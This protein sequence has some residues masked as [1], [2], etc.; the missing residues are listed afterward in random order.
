MRVSKSEAWLAKMV[1]CRSICRLTQVFGFFPHASQR[2]LTRKQYFLNQCP[3]YNFALSNVCIRYTIYMYMSSD[4]EKYYCSTEKEENVNV[5][6]KFSMKF[7]RFSSPKP[8]M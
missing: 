6:W 7:C 3:M 8:N 1:V 4:S 5:C 2:G